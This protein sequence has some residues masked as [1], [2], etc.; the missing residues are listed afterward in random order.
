MVFEH[1]A[2]G[3]WYLDA[4]NNKQHVGCARSFALFALFACSFCLL[5]LL[6]C[7]LPFLPKQTAGLLTIP[8]LRRAVLGLGLS[9]TADTLDRFV[10]LSKHKPLVDVVS[11]VYVAAMLGEG[12]AESPDD[13]AEEVLEVLETV[14]D[15]VSTAE[16][17]ASR[18]VWSLYGISGM[19]KRCWV[20]FVFVLQKWRSRKVWGLY[21]ISGMWKGC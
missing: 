17:L 12:P 2:F 1:L 18:K 16:E 20:F 3:I 14:R 9:D 10:K 5:C 7:R 8:Q 21:G 15:W 11:F 19:W 13:C 6:C 4:K